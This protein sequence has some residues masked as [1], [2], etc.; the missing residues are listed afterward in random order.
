MIVDLVR[1][2][3]GRVCEIGSVYVPRLMHVES[4]ATGRVLALAVCV[5]LS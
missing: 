3:I 4:F 5:C 2:D 1:N